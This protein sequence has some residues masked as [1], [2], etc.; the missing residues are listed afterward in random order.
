MIGA[1]AKQSATPS[2]SIC[3]MP[4]E[5]SRVK[6]DGVRENNLIIVN[7]TILHLGTVSH[8]LFY[9]WTIVSEA[10]PRIKTLAAHR[11]QELNYG[12]CA[13][14]RLDGSPLLLIVN[15]VSWKSHLFGV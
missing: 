8:F 7:V 9:V 3:K 12:I 10:Q 4:A 13:P 1:K 14:W 11:I 5:N 15:I 2:E 6:S